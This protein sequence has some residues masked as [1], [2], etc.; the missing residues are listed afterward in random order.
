M[1][2]PILHLA[3]ASLAGAF[4]A[5]LYL[6]ALWGSLRM[7]TVFVRP[8]PW[9]VASSAARLAAL[10]GGFWLVSAGQPLRLAATLVGFVVT[11]TIVV[12]LVRTRPAPAI[13]RETSP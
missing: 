2:D 8:G 3:A 6:S 12:G 13:R 10:M 1:N 5:L 7:I 4:L 11:R 9:I